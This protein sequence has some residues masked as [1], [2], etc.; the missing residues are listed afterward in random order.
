MLIGWFVMGCWR[1]AG[2]CFG[3]YINWTSFP[4]STHTHTHT[5]THTQPKLEVDSACVC[6]HVSARSCQLVRSN[7]NS[8]RGDSRVHPPAP[9]DA[10]THPHRDNPRITNAK[11]YDVPVCNGGGRWTQTATEEGL[12]PKTPTPFVASPRFSRRRRRRRCRLRRPV[13]HPQHPHPRANAIAVMPRRSRS[14]SSCY[15]AQALGGGA[16]IRQDDAGPAQ[17]QQPGY[18]PP[19]APQCLLRGPPPP[20]EQ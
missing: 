2:A 10:L 9:S 8:E 11:A 18:V 15:G 13:A 19:V 20:L 3:T 14:C 4:K 6:A 17:V 1:D 12:H 5:H 7:G 16:G